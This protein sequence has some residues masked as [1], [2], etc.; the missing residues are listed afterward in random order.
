MINILVTFSDSVEQITLDMK[1]SPTMDTFK[2]SLKTHFLYI[3]LFHILPFLFAYLLSVPQ[4]HLYIADTVCLTNMVL[5]LLVILL[6][7]LLLLQLFFSAAEA[8]QCQIEHYFGWVGAW[9]GGCLIISNIYLQLLSK[10][11]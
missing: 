10:P 4:I 8:L 5:L 6:V 11:H 2:H 7:L 1:F 3:I 9:E